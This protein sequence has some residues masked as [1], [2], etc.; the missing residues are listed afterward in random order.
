MV[1]PFSIIPEPMRPW[2]AWNPMV[3]VIQSY[4]RIGALGFFETPVAPP[5]IQPNEKGDVDLTFNVTEKQTG[6]VNFGTAVG[7]GSGLAG[8]LGYDQ[9]NLFGQA[10]AGHLRWEFGRYSN[11]FEASFSDPAILGSPY[12]GSLSL[13]S[14]RPPSSCERSCATVSA[15]TMLGQTQPTLP[16]MRA[17]LGRRSSLAA[18]ATRRGMENH[19]GADQPN[20]CA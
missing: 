15:S 20:C 8:F 12:S 11:N 1:Y 18:S 16:S 13:I 2:M 5:D 9:P 17:L 19:C 7:G 4:Q 14:E 6:S 10:K 3:P